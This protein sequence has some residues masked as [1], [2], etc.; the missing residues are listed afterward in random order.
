MELNSNNLFK[1]QRKE[2]SW[3]CRILILWNGITV[4]MEKD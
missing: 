4:L 3:I 2:E 1:T